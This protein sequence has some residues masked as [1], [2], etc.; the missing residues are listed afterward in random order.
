[1][2]G[3]SAPFSGA[4][5][6]LGLQFHLGAQLYFE[7][8][9]QK[10]GVNGRRIELKRLDDGYEPER[11][12]ENTRKLLADDVFALFGYIGTPTSVAALP[13]ATE[14][15]VPYFAPFTGAEVLRDPFN[16]YAIHVRASYYDETAAIVLHVVD[17]HPEAGLAP[18]MGTP[19]RAEFYKWLVWLTNTLQYGFCLVVGTPATA[20]ATEALGEDLW[21]MVCDG[22]AERLAL[23]VNT[24][25]L[26]LTAGVAAWR[27]WLAAGGAKPALVATQAGLRAEIAATKAEKVVDA[28]G[29]GDSFNGGY[30]SA[31][32][33]GASPEEAVR[34][35]HQVAGV[36]IGHKGALVDS[37]LVRG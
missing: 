5:E 30:L 31:R 9:N 19:Q 27:A 26:M 23:T 36:V 3:Q 8:L 25:P 24:Q 10:G 32:I 14:A 7:A 11:C 34:R 28:T 17:T 18:P 2:L 16:R 6:Q 20:E 21:A 33:A 4:A 12:A 37:A 13:L 22:P 35:G 1:M 29:A 15:K